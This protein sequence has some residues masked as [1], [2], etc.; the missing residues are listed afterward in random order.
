MTAPTSEELTAADVETYT[1]GR[2]LASDPET[3][4]M[5]DAALAAARREVGWHVSPVINETINMDGP[6]GYLLRLPTMKIVD[7]TEIVNDGTTVDLSTVTVSAQVGWRIS[8]TQGCW[9]W[10]D[11]AITVTLDHGF[12][13]DEAPDWRQAILSMVN[14]MM[15]LVVA[16]RPDAD[17]S[18]KQVDDVVYKWGAGYALPGAQPILEKYQL[19]TRGFA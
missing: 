4:R 17:L 2:L 18:S 10:K 15:E 14:Q 5:L 1:G 12:T 13:A 9:S 3:Q 7:L 16:G 11:A 6:G 19:P 8:L